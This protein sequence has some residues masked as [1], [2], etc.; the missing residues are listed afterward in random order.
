MQV[1]FTNFPDKL[2]LN[3]PQNIVHQIFHEMSNILYIP[4]FPIFPQIF[5]I[6]QI[7]R[8]FSSQW[9]FPQIFRSCTGSADFPDFPDCGK[10]PQI[11]R[12]KFSRF[13]ALQDPPDFPQIFRLPDFP[14]VR[15][16]VKFSA[17]KKGLD[18]SSPFLINNLPPVLPEF[19]LPNSALPHSMP[20]WAFW[21]ILFLQI[22]H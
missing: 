6:F 22:L 9:I 16:Q 5:Q 17:Q 21:R 14:P 13:S 19:F 8:R 2:T 18:F 11:F 4:D 12:V 20:V 10:F 7:L 15:Q 1:I 3:F